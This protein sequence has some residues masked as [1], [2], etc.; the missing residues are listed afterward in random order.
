M[1][2]NAMPS[3]EVAFDGALSLGFPSFGTERN[4]PILFMLSHV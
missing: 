2:Q 1:G 4:K 3:P